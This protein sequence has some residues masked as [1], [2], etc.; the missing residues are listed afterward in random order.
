M[1]ITKKMQKDFQKAIKAYRDS[2]EDASSYPKAMMTSQQMCKGTATVN[3]GR[4]EIGKNRAPKVMAFP[5]FVEW[6]ETYWIKS[7][8]IETV[9]EAS[10]MLPQ[11]QI[12]VT[13]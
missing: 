11:Y 12:R 7:I 9:Q 13:Y 1:E 8:Q 10:Y 2:Q 4:S 5:P 6:C 3:C